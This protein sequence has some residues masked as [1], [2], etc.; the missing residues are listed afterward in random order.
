MRRRIAWEKQD[1][2]HVLLKVEVQ[3]NSGT[4]QDAT[5]GYAISSKKHGRCFIMS[6]EHDSITSGRNDA[7]TMT[8][9]NL[10]IYNPALKCFE[11]ISV[12][13]KHEYYRKAVEGMKVRH[14][15]M[16]LMGLG[17]KRVSKAGGRKA[18]VYTIVPLSE[19]LTDKLSKLN[20]EQ[21]EYAT[22]TVSEDDLDID[23]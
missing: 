10:H 2:E 18:Y 20:Y 7:G 22:E 1:E 4:W 9:H 15:N 5:D 8:F 6:M 23:F 19:S 13:V 14:Q 12:L 3:T 11:P 17:V 21:P 16:F